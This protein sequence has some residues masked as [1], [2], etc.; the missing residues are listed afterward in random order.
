MNLNKTKMNPRDE[1]P[2][3]LQT[4]LAPLQGPYQIKRGGGTP[5]KTLSLYKS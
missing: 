4:L 1:K 5:L 2:T 3:N